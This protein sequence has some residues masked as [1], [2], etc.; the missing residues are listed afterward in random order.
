MSQL[1][2]EAIADARAV[3]AT[4]LANAKLALQ[5]HFT[6]TLTAQLSE[7]L[8]NELQDEE[9]DPTVAPVEAPAAP[10]PVATAPVVTAPVA[11]AAPSAE[12][13]D[14]IQETEDP[15]GSK[16][17]YTVIGNTPKLS[18]SVQ[19]EPS[20]QLAGEKTKDAVGIKGQIIDIK[21]GEESEENEESDELSDIRGELEAGCKSESIGEE[22]DEVSDDVSSEESHG[23]FGGESHDS[24]EAGESSEEESSEHNG[25]ESPVDSDETIN[26]DELMKE[27][28]GMGDEDAVPQEKPT[29]QT[30]PA[31]ESLR[32][33]VSNLKK[34]NSELSKAHS[35]IKGKLEEFNLLNA[36]LL[37]TNKLFRATNLSEKQKMKIVENMDLAKNTRE[38]K[39]VFSTIA[40]SFNFGAKSQ[41]PLPK[42]AVKTITEGLASKAVASTK[43]T[44][45]VITE[46][47]EMAQRF[48]KLAGIKRTV[49]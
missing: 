14:P 20:K 41:A 28:E 30:E 15:Q 45:E 29:V 31:M 8:R 24:H 43:P 1:L 38:V 40:E 19:S 48:Q 5:E 4:A 16:V 49:L 2:K 21:E 36:K 35:F 42:V 12:E 47:T 7:K 44:K 11:P 26:F 46:G 25:E 37:Y 17:K 3:R 27:I 34:Q 32:L 23:E 33:E 39:L 9:I 22:S 10:A 13:A 6:E 18:G